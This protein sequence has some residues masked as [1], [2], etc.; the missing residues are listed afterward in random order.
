MGQLSRSF[1]SLSLDNYSRTIDV[2]SDFTQICCSGC[3]SPKNVIGDTSDFLDVYKRTN[4]H[5]YVHRFYT[6]QGISSECRI[7]CD[8]TWHKE[9]TWFSDFW[10]MIINCAHC[11]LHWGWHFENRDGSQGF[12]GIRKDAVCLHPK[13]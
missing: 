12:Y 4:P 6:L 8:G 3:T 11:E 9:Y 2:G 1:S 5:G 7:K 13:K 10:W